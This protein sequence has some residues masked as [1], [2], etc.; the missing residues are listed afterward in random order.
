M[1]TRAKSKPWTDDQKAALS[2]ITTNCRKPNGQISWKQAQEQY[3]KEWALLTTE[4]GRDIGNI[5]QYWSFLNKGTKPVKGR[6]KRQTESMLP[7]HR[8]M[9]KLVG[10]TIHLNGKSLAVNVCP[11]CMANIAMITVACG[12]RMPQSCPNCDANL[13]AVKTAMN[14]P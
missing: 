14:M 5:H 9:T 4:A 8:E 1:Q 13:L 12:G 7:T 2:V 3:P 11:S 6:K 10:A